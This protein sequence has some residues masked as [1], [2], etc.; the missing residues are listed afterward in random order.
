MNYQEHRK[1]FCWHL[2]STVLNKKLWIIVEMKRSYSV[3]SVIKSI[4]KIENEHLLNIFYKYIRYSTF[5][6]SDSKLKIKLL[7][8]CSTYH[9][10]HLV[11]L[12]SFEASFSH[13]YKNASEKEWFVEKPNYFTLTLKC[14]FYGKSLLQRNLSD[15]YLTWRSF[16]E[17]RLK[18]WNFLE[19]LKKTF[20]EYIFID[21]I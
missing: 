11:S 12:L 8:V 10:K 5:F 20:N 7:I 15:L 3:F 1:N 17:R 4:S 6:S 16:K 14:I 19:Y 9:Y 18:K 21:Q 13:F 2:N